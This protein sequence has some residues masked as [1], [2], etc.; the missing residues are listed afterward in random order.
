MRRLPHA[1]RDDPDKCLRSTLNIDRLHVCYA[2]PSKRL[3]HG[4]VSAP[5]YVQYCTL[6]RCS[7]AQRSSARPCGDRLKRV[8]AATKIAGWSN[9]HQASRVS[10]VNMER[11]RQ[12]LNGEARPCHSRSFTRPSNRATC[13]QCVRGVWQQALSLLSAMSIAGAA[14]EDAPRNNTSCLTRRLRVTP[15]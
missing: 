14:S 1:T 7:G 10:L 13:L 11:K 6:Q 9:L 8:A 5:W 4:A 3:R 15:G 2:S 12:L